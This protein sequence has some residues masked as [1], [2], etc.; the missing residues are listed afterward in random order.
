MSSNNLIY[1]NQIHKNNQP[2]YYVYAYLRSKDSKTAKA[3]T[4]YYIGK[5]KHRRAYSSHG[6]VPVPFD[7]KFI[8]FL[9]TNL[10]EL[11]AFALERRLILYWGRKDINT[12][13]LLNRSNGGQLPDTLSKES[14]EKIG[15]NTSQKFKDPDSGYNNL[16][17]RNH[18]KNLAKKTWQDPN[19]VYNSEEYRNNLSEKSICAWQDPNSNHNTPEGR[20]NMGLSKRKQYILTSPEGEVFTVLGLS[21]FC[22]LHNLQQSNLT[23][24]AAGERSQHKG[25]KCQFDFET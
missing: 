1:K 11:G 4:P 17:F 7:K 9:E 18:L 6:Q 12:G 16:S 14:K 5:G 8:I 20:K 24:V 25:W 15:Y 19:S 3:G 22:K 13:I 23:K 2:V 10:T 21:D